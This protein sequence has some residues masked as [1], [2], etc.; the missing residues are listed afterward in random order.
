MLDIDFGTY[1][2]VT[3][4]TTVT[5]GACIGMGIAPNKV[6]EVYGIFKAYCTRVGSGPFP[7]ELNDKDGETLREAGHEFGATT[8]RPR[9]CGWLDLVQL[10]YA[11]MVNGVSQLIMMKADV[12]SGFET[13]KVATAYEVNGEITEE[14]PF[15][16][17]DADIKPIYTELPGWNC[18]LT[19]LRSENEFPEELN[20]YITWLE[21][22]L[23]V[24]IRIVSV[25]P[26]RQ[27]TIIRYR[28]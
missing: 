8:G 17:V 20:N 2:F 4:S 27:Q 23:R 25:G 12:L 14:F 5:A 11:I 24:P 6:G 7:T 22:E 26:D 3:S 16:V 19:G 9:R 21:D 15:E 1:P 28:D 10:K 18:D 13:I